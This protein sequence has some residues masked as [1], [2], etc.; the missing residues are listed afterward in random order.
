G[1][2]FNNNGICNYNCPAGQFVASNEGVGQ[3]RCANCPAIGSHLR[4]FSTTQQCHSC[5]SNY[6]ANSTGERCAECTNT[7]LT[8]VPK[9][10]CDRCPNRYFDEVAQKC[11]LCPTGQ[12]ASDDGL[13]CIDL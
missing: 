3:W 10:E 9:S 11:Y 6:Y 4:P 2:I 8:S 1:N 7:F 13:S 12:K 5:G